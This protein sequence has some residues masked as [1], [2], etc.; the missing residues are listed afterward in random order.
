MIRRYLYFLYAMSKLRLMGYAL[1]QS[2][3]YHYISLKFA[4][5]LKRS[6]EKASK[7]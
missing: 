5:Y 4:N 2:S 6:E 1:H 7:Y 3:T